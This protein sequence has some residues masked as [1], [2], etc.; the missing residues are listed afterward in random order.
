MLPSRPPRAF[1]GSRLGWGDLPR[2]VRL[3]IAE[4]AGADVVSETTATNGFSPGFA[5]RLELGDGTEV[6][7]KAVS[8]E[9]NPTS[10]HLA[11]AEAAVTAV[12]PPEARAPELLWWHDDGTWVLLGSRAV[13]G[14]APGAPWVQA[15]LDRALGAV[16]DLSDVR[17]PAGFRPLPGLLDEVVTG[18]AR[19]ADDPAALALVLDVVPEHAHWLERS[20]PVLVE[21]SGTAA[22]ACAG[23]RLVHG[24]L[25]G[26]NMLLDGHEVWLVDW[27]HAAVGC[28]W[29]DLVAML[30]SVAMQGGG[31][32]AELFAGHPAAVG[33]DGG[34]VRAVLAGITGYFLE[35]AVRPAP[36]G[37]PNLRAF[38]LGQGRAA[39]E[40]LRSL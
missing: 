18:W 38:Q 6:F 26:D 31:A 2:D 17:A 39:L 25:R 19:L 9:H 10:P 13:D 28:A 24:D 23:D 40:W 20:L 1:S 11:R 15:D 8:A 33:A 14:D 12:L 16:A 3:R 5:S 32:P 34:D 35:S 21:R 27:A 37:I 7:V 29:F 22:A 4:L 30:P 36:P